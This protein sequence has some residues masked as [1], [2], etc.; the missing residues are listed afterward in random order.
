MNAYAVCLQI[1]V[2]LKTRWIF[3]GAAEGKREW[4]PHYLGEVADKVAAFA[5]VLGEDVEKEGL[6]IVVEG[7]VVQEQFSKQTQVLTVDCAHIPINLLK[8]ICEKSVQNTDIPKQLLSPASETLKHRVK[9]L[10][11]C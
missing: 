9:S 2:W 8:N 10:S 5:V 3:D 7:L 4:K 6:H 1:H 11:C